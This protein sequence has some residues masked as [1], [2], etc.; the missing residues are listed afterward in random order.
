[1]GKRYAGRVLIGLAFSLFAMVMHSPGVCAREPKSDVSTRVHYK[2]EAR[3][4]KVFAEIRYQFEMHGDEPETITILPARF[5]LRSLES[6]SDSVR[7]SKKGGH[8]QGYLPGTGKHEIWVECLLHAQPRQGIQSLTLPLMQTANCEVSFTVDRPGM[9][10]RSR[11]AVPMKTE[12]GEET[13]SAR[14]YPAGLDSLTLS[15]QPKKRDADREPVFE[16]REY[17]VINL[18]QEGVRRHSALSVNMRRGT[19]D[20]LEIDIPSGVNVLGVSG[21]RPLRKKSS[22]RPVRRLIKSW[23]LVGESESRKLV[24]EFRKAIH[25]TAFL[26]ILSEQVGGGSTGEITFRPFTTQDANRRRGR[27]NLLDVPG[28]TLNVMDTNGLQRADT[29]DPRNLP[30]QLRTGVPEHDN[31]A[32]AFQFHQLPATVRIRLAE[33]NPQ[34]SAT[35]LAFSRLQAGIVD[36]QSKVSCQIETRAT[37]LIRLELDEELLILNVTGKCVAGWEVQNDRLRVRLRK[38]IRGSCSFTLTGVQHLRRVNGVLIPHLRVL[39]STRQTGHVGVSSTSDLGLV[40]NQ[41]SGYRQ[42]EAASVPQW[43]AEKRPKLSYSYQISGENDD[44]QLAVSTKA[45]EPKLVVRGQ[46]VAIIGEE[47]VDEEYIFTCE[48]SQQQ[49]FQLIIQVPEG[50]NPINLFGDQ[51]TDWEFHPESD[52]ISV[53][54]DHGLRGT[55]RLHLF[56]QRMRQG[57]RR[58][59]AGGVTIRGADH[60]TGAFGVGSDANLKVVADQTRGMNPIGVR[61]CPPLI[62]THDDVNLGFK[63]SGQDWSVACRTSRLEPLINATTRTALLVGDGVINVRSKIKWD[64]QRATIEKLQI[65]LP[66]NATPKGVQ[67]PGIQNAN[68]SD[69][70]WTVR[71]ADATK[72][73]YELKANYEMLVPDSGNPVEFPGVHLPRTSRQTGTLALYLRDPRLELSVSQLHNLRRTPQ[74]RSLSVENLTPLETFTYSGRERQLTFTTKGHALAAGVQ[75]QA[76]QVHLDT[77]VK[78]EGRAVSY[79]E[80]QV[81]NAGEQYFSLKL[82]R[83]SI[84]WGTYVEQE[85]VRPIRHGDKGLSIPLLDAPRDKPFTLAVIWSQPSP[86]LG[87]GS[88]LDLVAP[89][90]DLPAQNVHWNLRLPREYQM[91]NNGG[92]MKLMRRTKWYEQGLPAVVRDYA[93]A[94]WPV[95]RTILKIGLVIAAALVLIAFLIMLMKRLYEW[96]RGQMNAEEPCWAPVRITHIVCFVLFILLIGAVIVMM[97]LPTLSRARASAY[98]TS[99]INNLKQLG[100][101][102]TM[103]RNKHDGRM[104]PNLQTLVDEGYISAETL[105]SPLTGKRYQYAG[106]IDTDKNAPD[107]PLAWDPLDKEGKAILYLDSHVEYKPLPGVGRAKTHVSQLSQPDEK[108]ST[109][110]TAGAMSGRGASADRES[111]QAVEANSVNVMGLKSAKQAAEESPE[112]GPKLRGYGE[113]AG[114]PAEGADKERTEVQDQLKRKKKQKRKDI[115]TRALQMA[116]SY[117]RRGKL[118]KAEQKY[119]QAL[120][121]RPGSQKARRGLKRV[122]KLQDKGETKKEQPVTA[123]YSKEAE[124]RPQ[125]VQRSFSLRSLLSYRNQLRQ[126]LGDDWNDTLAETP[127][128]A[129]IL[130]IVSGDRDTVD[131]PNDVHVERKDTSIAVEGLQPEVRQFA[132]LLDG[133]ESRA[134]KQAREI[135]R[136]KQKAEQERATRRRVAARRRE[137]A[138]QAS[139]QGAGGTVSGSRGAGTLPIEIAFPGFGTQ[140]YPFSMQYAGT[141]QARLQI[142]CLRSGA[143]MVLQGAVIGIVWLVISLIAWKSL[144]GGLIVWIVLALA[145][146]LLL[147]LSMGAAT[148]YVTM[149]L[150]GVVLAIPVIMIRFIEHTRIL[151]YQKQF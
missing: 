5:S 129:R 88:A 54:F 52:L 60:I 139:A 123:A 44:R 73:T 1:M 143:T 92:N 11:P 59:P 8:Y 25:S 71:L 85:P 19:I 120:S 36:I 150:V 69:G 96:L 18:A 86:D 3:Q 37:D 83:G 68:F 53:D 66:S 136:R 95:M 108:L 67:G 125:K 70:A 26:R 151:Y 131:L 33:L 48:V 111:T 146:G 133:L 121:A 127:A 109:E 43:L 99:T 90:L 119:R 124:P 80:C 101:A 137:A 126:D 93:G 149:A 112:E 50:L 42:V 82:P 104:P 141:S 115:H 110:A 75:L 22:R 14:L 57:K 64:I 13:T 24:V 39:N 105:K 142:T 87:L 74:A 4:G 103:F 132:S 145:C 84:L 79:M 20:H 106:P 41:A 38:P 147:K 144:R 9:V 138:A 55:T 94:T 148:Q 61:D 40:H 116:E 102:I 62:S 76:K 65:V 7:V 6:S 28:H 47:A 34:I 118:N 15:W 134:L 23:R 97:F 114:S 58:I 77:V 78:R 29:G 135:T 30:R 35:V 45:V 100:N 130:S 89:R 49:L 140:K 17:S 32:L 31:L 12:R 2:L 91:V 117:R 16:T 10:I 98:R 113:G 51:I 21:V 122:Q 63:W 27:F 107:T 56:G 81:E 46:G 128:E 72:G